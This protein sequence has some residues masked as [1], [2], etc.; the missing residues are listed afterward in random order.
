[1]EEIQHRATPARELGDEDD[2]DLARLSKRED[3]FPFGPIILGAGCG[4]FPH[5]DDL[6]SGLSLIHI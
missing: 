2:I 6:V 1:M 4:L 5:T 3:F